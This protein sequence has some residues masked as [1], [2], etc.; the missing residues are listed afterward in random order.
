MEYY[1]AIKKKETDILDFK[2]QNFCALKA[3]IK[4]VKRQSTHL[5]I[6]Y[7]MRVC[8]FE[9]KE[10]SY[11]SSTKSQAIQYKNRQRT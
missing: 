1:L 7:L 11:N 10:N 3:T 6:M 8:Y 5:E 4:K 2:I 9:Y